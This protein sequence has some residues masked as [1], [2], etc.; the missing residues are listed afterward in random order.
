MEQKYQIFPIFPHPKKLQKTQNLE[1]KT[2]VIRSLLVRKFRAR[3]GQVVAGR[4]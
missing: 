2:V 4:V 3:F 1:L